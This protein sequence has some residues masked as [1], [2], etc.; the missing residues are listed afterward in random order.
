MRRV[1]RI[2]T[3][4]ILV[5]FGEF[6][7]WTPIRILVRYP[8]SLYSCIFPWFG[9]NIV[10]DSDSWWRFCECSQASGHGLFDTGPLNRCSV[11]HTP[12]LSPIPN[13][14]HR[15]SPIAWRK[16]KRWK[17]NAVSSDLNYPNYLCQYP[18]F[19]SNWIKARMQI[20]DSPIQFS[21]Y[22]SYQSIDSSIIL[23][24]WNFGGRQTDWIFSFPRIDGLCWLM[25]LPMTKVLQY[26]TESQPDSK[27]EE[28][29]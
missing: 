5:M 1:G 10:N 14:H 17:S 23:Q 20:L 22:H 19:K 8:N 24:T 26:L 25:S 4:L 15:H 18:F 6:A 21:F 16:G 13:P 28:I 3:S 7:E 12:L 9:N 2:G 27:L 11:W 29:D